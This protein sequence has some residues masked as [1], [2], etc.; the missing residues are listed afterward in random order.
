MPRL[1]NGFSMRHPD[2]QLVVV[3][4]PN[5]AGKSTLA[6]YL[7]RGE[8]KLSE[9]VNADRIALGLSGF[10]AQ[11]NVA[12]EAGRVMIDRMRNL[13]NMRASFA[14]ETTMASRSFA[15]WISGLVETGYR[16]HILYIWLR[17][18]ELAIERVGARVRAGGHSV[19]AEVVKRRYK[20]GIMNFLGLYR[21]IGNTWAVYDNS[22]SGE[23]I[24]IAEKS[25]NK[26][27]DKIHR[28]DLWTRFC[29][30]NK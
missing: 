26:G 29:H 19:D 6:P 4:G 3:A 28:Q 18:P 11:Q 27:A 9:Y 13:A 22:V 14:F 7:L 5:G 16:V 17:T 24:L 30:T 8:Y 21:P 1:P 12:I 2:P 20:R 15:R 25:K 23:P 10:E